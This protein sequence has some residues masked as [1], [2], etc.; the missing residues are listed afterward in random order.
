MRNGQRGQ[1]KILWAP[2]RAH[3]VKDRKKGG[4]V[5]CE[6]MADPSG[7]ES[8]VL[9]KTS[10]VFIMMNRYPYAHG[11]LLVSPTRHV[12]DLEGLSREE[13]CELMEEIRLA[14]MVL[15]QTMGPQGF[16]VG[17]NLGEVA[18]A[19]YAGHLHVH[20]VPRWN[21]DLNFMPIIAEVKVISEHLLETH[22]KLKE[23]FERVKGEGST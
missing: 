17:I 3:Y 1:T 22:R 23:E 4:C 14:V 9:R 16:N 11:H 18:G 7:P 21:G 15:R 20:I 2:W 12:A 6:A 8:L 19:G 13:A 10:S 5:F